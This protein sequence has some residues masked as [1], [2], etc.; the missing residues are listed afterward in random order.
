MQSLNIETVN[1]VIHIVPTIS[2][3]I[4]F[5]AQIVRSKPGNNRLADDQ[6]IMTLPK[7]ERARL[8]HSLVTGEAI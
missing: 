3:D 1:S 2:G 5:I 7:S 4:E 8:A 6:N